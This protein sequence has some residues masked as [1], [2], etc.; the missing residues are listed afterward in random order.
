MNIR[1]LILPI[2][3][4][5]LTIGCGK[6]VATP[7]V[8]SSHK[9]RF[10]ADQLTKIEYDG[11]KSTFEDD[12]VVGCVIAQ[13][14]SD[15]SFTYLCNS[16][17]HYKGGYLILDAV[18]PNTS[19][20]YDETGETQAANTIIRRYNAGSEDGFL[21]LKNQEIDY[22]FFFYHPYVDS[23]NASSTLTG[24]V[25]E[26]DGWA[27]PVH[28]TPWSQWPVAVG[29]EHKDEASLEMDDILWVNY[30]VDYSDASK[31]INYETATYTVPLEFK[32]KTAT[33][34][35]QADTDISD[36]YF[37][38]T[39][40]IIRGKYLNLQ[41]GTYS[42]IDYVSWATDITNK[43]QEDDPFYPYA[44]DT[45]NYRIMFP[46][47]SG[48]DWNLHFVLNDTEYTVEL[49]GDIPALEEDKLYIIH[50]TKGGEC[51]LE[52]VDWERGTYGQLIEITD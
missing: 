8:D 19:T 47:Q 26:A 35:V 1:H 14:A 22:S 52:I 50:I 13:K 32:K 27:W 7:E 18:M 30:T 34:E 24:A 42:D 49:E 28:Y 48:M 33:V 21:E 43:C 2:A 44:Y 31:N 39:S 38:G 46:P 25:A 3:A 37:Q 29:I 20:T 23:N 4:L 5:L 9:F 17:W 12:D 6:Q 16:K 51:T 41:D 10:S 36:V 11:L 15:G 45:Q 40:Y